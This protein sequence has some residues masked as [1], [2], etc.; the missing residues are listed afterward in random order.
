[1]LAERFAVRLVEKTTRRAM[2]ETMCGELLFMVRGEVGGSLDT[3][4]N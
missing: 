1:M 4:S 3:N 2:R